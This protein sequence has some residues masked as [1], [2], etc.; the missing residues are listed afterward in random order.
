MHSEELTV[1]VLQITYPNSEFM[2]M[3]GS[4]FLSCPIC[5]RKIRG[6][7]KGLASLLYEKSKSI[8]TGLGA[9]LRTSLKYI[10]ALSADTMTIMLSRLHRW[11]KKE[12]SEKY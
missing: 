1:S 2:F 11:K 6:K 12:F 8:C 9:F 10:I 7:W 5:N 4:F 3:A